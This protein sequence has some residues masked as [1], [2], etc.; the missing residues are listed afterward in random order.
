[1]VAARRIDP[2]NHSNVA[3]S[4]SSRLSFL[5]L[6]NVLCDS[7]DFMWHSVTFENRAI[8]AN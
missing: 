4:S 6:F 7:V 1:M 2:K 3:F 8:D 5:F